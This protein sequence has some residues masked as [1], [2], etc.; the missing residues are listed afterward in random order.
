MAPGQ[1]KGGET[2]FWKDPTS[3]VAVEGNTLHESLYCNRLRIVTVELFILILC[4][5]DALSLLG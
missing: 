3:K 1:V 4:C 2:V 5:K